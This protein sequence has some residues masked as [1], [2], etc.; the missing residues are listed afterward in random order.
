MNALLPLAVRELPLT[1]LDFLTAFSSP[2][3]G[4]QLQGS[5]SEDEP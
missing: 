5:L 2:G 1:E 4:Y 3:G